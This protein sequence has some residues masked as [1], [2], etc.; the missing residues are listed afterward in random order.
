[1][2]I[3]I[4]QHT[5]RSKYLVVIDGDVYVYE[6]EKYKFDPPFVSFKPKHI[7]IGKSKVCDV[8]EFSEAANDDS[9]FE[10][11]T[12]LL[13]VEDR[14]YVYIS[15]LENTEFETS[16]KVIDCISVKGNNM[17]PYTRREINIFLIRSLQIY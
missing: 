7:F 14:K 3:Y 17:V 5:Y 2:D 15:G 4:M 1:M 13:E 6:Y 11:N 9:D 16:D 12:L 10:D 8:T